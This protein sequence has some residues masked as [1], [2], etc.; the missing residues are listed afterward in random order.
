MEVEAKLE[1]IAA[2]PTPTPSRSHRDF[3]QAIPN[4]SALFFVY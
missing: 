2:T 4:K 1:D 3:S